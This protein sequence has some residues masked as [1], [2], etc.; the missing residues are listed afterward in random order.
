MIPCA[1]IVFS[2][3][4][5]FVVLDH[6]SVFK[7]D[8]GRLSEHYIFIYIN[9][10]QSGVDFFFFNFEFPICTYLFALH[11]AGLMGNG[12]F[13]SSFSFNSVPCFI[14]VPNLTTTL[15]IFVTPTS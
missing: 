11:K 15:T 13:F 8:L 1:C 14:Q 12:T 2:I 9:K 3:S 4:F 10:V 7:L 6:L 5:S